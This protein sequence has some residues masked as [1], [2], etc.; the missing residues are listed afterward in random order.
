VR[1]ENAYLHET[2]RTQSGRKE[3]LLDALGEKDPAYKD[4]NEQDAPGKAA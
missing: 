2:T 1:P 4:A 3:E